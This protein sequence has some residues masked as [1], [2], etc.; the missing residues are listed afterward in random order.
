MT[1]NKRELK[2]MISIY[3]IYKK[4]PGGSLL[5]PMFLIAI[6]NTIFPNLLA[7]FGG[8]TTAMF[9]TGTMAFAAAILFF[10]GAGIKAKTLG[11]V[12]KRCGI[13]TLM[14]L[15]IAFGFGFLFVR[16]FGTDGFLGI[17]TVAFVTCICSCNPGVFM[18]LA[19]D[20]GEAG[21]MG[22]FAT[23]NIVSMPCWPMLILAAAAGAKFN[24]M[25]LVTV[26][27]PFLL[28]MLLG[29][30]DPGFAKIVGPANAALIPLMGC[31]FGSTL[32]LVTAVKAG[33]AGLLLALL[34]LVLNVP[35]MLFADRVLARRPGY[36]AVSWCSIAGIAMT[37]PAMAESL[38]A[39][40]PTI[41]TASAQIGLAMIVTCIVSPFLTKWVVNKW[42]SPK[43]PA[44][45]DRLPAETA[46]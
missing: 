32:N 11:T 35:F 34:Y 18:G 16:L 39:F 7:S 30:L 25:D 8:M 12:I 23:M 14:K 28:G 40:A 31:C 13:L 24:V 3:G 22:N 38:E 33:G 29:N 41:A 5:V 20:Y 9:K 37:V 46:K 1:E 44:K 2:R 36:A 6:I 27:V 17:T 4:I 21:D 45:K 10:T 26:F 42:G 15:A 43:V 19:A